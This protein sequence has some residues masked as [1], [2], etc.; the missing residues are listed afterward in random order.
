MITW[1]GES[2]RYSTWKRESSSS[3]VFEIFVVAEERRQL[4]LSLS[5]NMDVSG[6]S[7]RRRGGERNLPTNFVADEEGERNSIGE[8]AYKRKFEIDG[9]KGK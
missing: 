7:C 5:R 6:F 3:R 8:I 2:G 4:G 9:K 1:K